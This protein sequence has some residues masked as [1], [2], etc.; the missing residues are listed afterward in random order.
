MAISLVEGP[1]RSSRSGGRLPLPGRRSSIVV[2]V[3]SAERRAVVWV[4]ITLLPSSVCVP[5]AVRSECAVAMP[6]RPWPTCSTAQN[7]PQR[8]AGAS[9]RAMMANPCFWG[10]N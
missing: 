3:L 8:S 1:A 10:L 5:P 6:C 4:L 7:P 2:P 9:R